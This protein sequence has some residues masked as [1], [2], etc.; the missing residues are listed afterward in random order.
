VGTPPDGGWTT[1]AEGGP[2]AGRSRD[3]E[4]PGPG[5]GRAEPVGG[6]PDRWRPCRI[7]LVDDSPVFLPA[8]RDFLA[9]CEWIEVVG[10]ASSGKEAVEGA[11]R[12]RPDLILMDFSM[13]IMDGAEACRRISAEPDAPPVV[14][15]TLNDRPPYREAAERAGA[16]GFLSKT[17]LGEGLPAMIRRL[18]PGLGVPGGL[19]S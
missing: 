6:R 18:L 1:A 17:R 19:D 13:P 12:L 5:G 8:A 16:A 14:I 7:L 3:R 2:G 15:M 11:A 4:G 9:A 10:L